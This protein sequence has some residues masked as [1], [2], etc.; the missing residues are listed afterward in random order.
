MALTL[1]WY[2]LITI[3]TAAEDW[4][5]QTLHQLHCFSYATSAGAAA[6]VLHDLVL[7]A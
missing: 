1:H 3:G 6:P 4:L 7:C 2:V 5:L